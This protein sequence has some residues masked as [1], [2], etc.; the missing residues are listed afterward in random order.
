[1]DY[2]FILQMLLLYLIPLYI[3]NAFPVLIKKGKPIDFGKSYGGKRILGDGKTIQG[4]MAGVFAGAVSGLLICLIFSDL[5]IIQNYFF[6][7]FLLSIG[8]MFGDCAESFFKRRIGI[9][10][11]GR[12]LFADQLDFVL[13]GLLF[14]LLFRIPEIELV[15]VLIILTLIFHTLTNNFAYK[16]KL[17]KVP[18]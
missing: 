8:A 2:F 16:L 10:R 12:W 18:W 14:S 7:A 5:L 6:L 4:V 3:A 15:V 1:M 17:K 13:G 9:K 11:G